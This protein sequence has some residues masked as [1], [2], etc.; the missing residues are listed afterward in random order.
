MSIVVSY[1]LESCIYSTP[2]IFI[3]TA[4]VHSLLHCGYNIF[5]ELA[6]F[7]AIFCK[8]GTKVALTVIML[9]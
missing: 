5:I 2:I 7:Y 3:V 1:T 4:K 8:V 9:C 6:I